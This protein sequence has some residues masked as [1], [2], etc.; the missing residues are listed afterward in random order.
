MI[1]RTVWYRMRTLSFIDQCS[2]SYVSHRL[3][4]IS[5]LPGSSPAALELGHL[6]SNLQLNPIPPDEKERKKEQQV[7]SSILPIPLPPL[8]A[9]LIRKRP[10]KLLIGLVWDS[11]RF[12]AVMAMKSLRHLEVRASR[13]GDAT[14]PHLDLSELL[15]HCPALRYIFRPD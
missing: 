5:C 13:N 15:Q 3:H 1:Y 7:G 9:S 11:S 2:L 12:A 8:P 6:V 10:R 4:V 14:V